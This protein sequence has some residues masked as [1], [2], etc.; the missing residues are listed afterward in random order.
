MRP[1]MILRSQ[2]GAALLILMLALFMVTMTVLLKGLN[3]RGGQL[4]RQTATIAALMQAKEALI[5]YAV[6]VNGG[7]LP[8]P[9]TSTPPCEPFAI[10]RLPQSLLDDPSFLADFGSG[11]DQQFW[12]GVG[13]LTVD[14]NSA[15]A[16]LIAPGPSLAGQNRPSTNRADYL[17]DANSSGT[18]FSS[19]PNSSPETFND[20]VVGIAQD[21]ID[22]LFNALEP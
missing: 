6:V 2:Q 20:L 1:G 22:D 5:G 17:E 18:D 12:Y 19:S 16:V 7:V 4:E 11:I 21:E 8:C 15:A 13:T 3:N 14:G 10:G 9:E